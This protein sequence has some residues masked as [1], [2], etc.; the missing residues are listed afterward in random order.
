[1]GNSMREAGQVCREMLAGLIIWMIVTAVLLAVIATNKP[2]AL[3]GVFVGTI[4]AAGVILH[5]YRHLD[6]ALDMDAK[7]AQAHTQV[8]A[9]QRMFIMAAVIGVSMVFS[10]YIHPVGVVLGLFGVKATALCNPLIHKQMQ[11]LRKKRTA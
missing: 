8:A 7:H 10:G 1:M 9:F 3:A 5:M 6:I 2:A 11:K 4:T